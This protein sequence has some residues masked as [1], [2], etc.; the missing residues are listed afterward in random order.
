MKKVLFLL[1]TILLVF[2]LTACGDLNKILE[3]FNVGDL[4]GY[5]NGN[6]TTDDG[7]TETG[8]GDTGE[9]EIIESI[10]ESQSVLYTMGLTTGFEITFNVGEEEEATMGYKNNVLWLNSE[11][12]ST[13]YLKGEENLVHVFSSEEGEYEY[14]GSFELA[15]EEMYKDV[16]SV[17][18]S[19]AEVYKSREYVNEGTEKIAGHTCTKY[20]S[21]F[22]YLNN[23]ATVSVYVDV[24]TGL[25]FKIDFKESVNGE[26]QEGTLLEILE[27]KVGEEINVPEVEAP[28]ELEMIEYYNGSDSGEDDDFEDD[29]DDGEEEDYE[30]E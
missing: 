16:T 10:E 14:H 5:L 7:N 4:T 23:Y 26:T 28:E 12:S 19:T 2:S 17:I 18:F 11:D 25:I 30:E 15:F 1:L 29:F 13:V 24:E 21:T 3:S 6:T 20:T 8:N 22:T 9:G 27:L